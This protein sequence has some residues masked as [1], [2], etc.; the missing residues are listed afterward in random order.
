MTQV[1]RL[2]EISSDPVHLDSFDQFATELIS[3]LETTFSRSKC[4]SSSVHSSSVARGKLWTDIHLER[5][6]WTKFASSL[7]VCVDALIQQV[8][9]R[10]LY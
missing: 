3:A 4:Q 10:K 1:T 9:N 7:V 2:K 6:I 8:V 5:D